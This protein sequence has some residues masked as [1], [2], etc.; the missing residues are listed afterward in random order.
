MSIATTAGESAGRARGRGLYQRLAVSVGLV[1]AFGLLRYVPAPLVDQ[2]AVRAFWAASGRYFEEGLPMISL[3]ALGLMPF[4]TGFFIVGLLARVVP[5]WRRAR[6]GGEA[7]QRTLRHA[8]IVVS[9][10]I[11][12][13][14]AFGMATF[15]RQAGESFGQELVRLS[16]GVPLGVL[17]VVLVAGSALL[18]GLGGWTTR[19]GLGSGFALLLAWGPAQLQVLALRDRI[20]AQIHGTPFPSSTAPDRP[21]W[22]LAFYPVLVA[23]VIGVLL[24]LKLR[25]EGRGASVGVPGVS[26][27]TDLKA[28]LRSPIGAG[29][30][31]VLLVLVVTGALERQLA[32]GFTVLLA[33]ALAVPGLMLLLD[34]V[35]EGRFLAEHREVVEIGELDDA[36]RARALQ[37]RLS[38]KG[39]PMLAKSYHLRSLLR[40]LLAIVKIQVLVPAEH[41]TAAREALAD[42]ERTA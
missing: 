32:G 13:I 16:S 23:L 18:Y 39:V 37:A 35:D 2:G 6:R 7:G 11:A 33:V 14:Q 36:A 3:V 34:L 27:R 22:I 30:A 1:V 10:L 41:V 17:A 42:V 5:A 4:V 8:S 38:G 9:V 24:A 29:L 28:F 31:V 26:L 40:V 12:A 25:A 21:T 19:N 20:L 15:L